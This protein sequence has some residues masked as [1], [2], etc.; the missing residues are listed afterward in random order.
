PKVIE[1]VTGEKISADDLGGSKVH[2]SKSGNAHINAK[3]EAEALNKVRAILSYLPGSNAD[4]PPITSHDKED[5]H[6][7]SELTEIVPYDATKTYDV[8]K[9]I[10]EI[11]D[12]DSYLE[13]HNDFAKNHVVVLA[14]LNG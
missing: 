7:R 3:D 1:T 10:N 4:S 2:N 6:N 11:V 12:A 5:D 14:R 8:K 9:V 13:L